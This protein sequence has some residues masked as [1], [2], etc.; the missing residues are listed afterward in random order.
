MPLI[1]FSRG[2]QSLIKVFHNEGNTLLIPKMALKLF[3]NISFQHT[4]DLEKSLFVLI[5]SQF[6]VSN[7]FFSLRN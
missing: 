6:Y 5:Q 3:L 2:Q 4:V 7:S 1:S